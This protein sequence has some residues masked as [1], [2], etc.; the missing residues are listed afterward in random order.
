MKKLSADIAQ[1][2]PE[3]IDKI[4]SLMLCDKKIY[5]V[6]NWPKGYRYVLEINDEEIYQ[7]LVELGLTPAKSNIVKFPEMPPEC[8]RHFI[9][10]CWDGD[11]S[12]YL[13]KN[14]KIG[15]SFVSGSKK[16]I[17][18]IVLEL[19]KVG[20]VRKVFER[21]GEETS[22]ELTIHKYKGRDAYYIKIG[23]KQCE[24]LFHYLYD[25]VDESLYLKRKYDIFYERYTTRR[26]VRKGERHFCVRYIDEDGKRRRKYFWTDSE[27]KEF[28][29]TVQPDMSLNT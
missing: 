15:A 24:R 6:R 8:I 28:R 16:F 25:R 5:K 4:K 1:K 11:G 14:G 10:G 18:R 19:Y 29:A 20:I 17:K 12:V 9:R 22:R 27:A 13:E 23:G 21:Y 2:S 3:I 26:D 7:D